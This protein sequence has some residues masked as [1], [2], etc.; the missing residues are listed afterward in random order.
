MDTVSNKDVVRRIYEDVVN[1]QRFDLLDD[2]FSPEFESQCAA[3]IWGTFWGCPVP[4]GPL[5]LQ[6]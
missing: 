4:V 5:R 6:P 3:R 2:Y 1:A